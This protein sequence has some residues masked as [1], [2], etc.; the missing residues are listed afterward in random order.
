MT[1]AA[2]HEAATDTPYY[3]IPPTP[4]LIPVA[5]VREAIVLRNE[6]DT[7]ILAQ[8]PTCQVRLRLTSPYWTF[9]ALN[10]HGHRKTCGG[11]EFYV[12]YHTHSQSIAGNRPMAVA[13][14]ADHEDGTY[15]LDFCQ[16]PLNPLS[17]KRGHL[18]VHFQ[19]TSAIGC[20]PPPS[21]DH[22]QHGGYTHTVYLHR[23]LPHAPPILR[24]FLPPIP[25]RLLSTFDRVFAFGDSILEQ[26]VQGGSEGCQLIT[27]GTKVATPLRT[28]TLPRVLDLLEASLGPALAAE[29][30]NQ[31]TALILNSAL[32]EI[33]SD[34]GVPG[35]DFA[36][37][38]TTCRTYVTTVQRRYPHVSVFWLSPS[39]VH[40]HRVYLFNELAQKGIQHKIDRV[41]YMSA[42]RTR[43][44]YDLQNGSN[45]TPPFS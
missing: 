20:A 32:W 24:P 6:W 40:I 44:L 2:D 19:Y 13:I 1:L 8:A 38:L 12:C 31:S 28:E 15:T 30:P 29:E 23:N 41:R 10:E 5:R 11:D 16:S 17:N 34:Q 9:E 4:D 21:K 25:S 14:I 33:L 45:T 35:A 22:W 43:R 27:Y 37:H 18:S 7:H 42:S 3:L 39:A 26:L 36:D